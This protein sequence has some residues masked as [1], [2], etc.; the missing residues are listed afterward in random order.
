LFAPARAAGIVHIPRANSL[1]TVQMG[2]RTR[3]INDFEPISPSPDKRIV[4]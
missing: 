2:C 1:L 4:R 3:T